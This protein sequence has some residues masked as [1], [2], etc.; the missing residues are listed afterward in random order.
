M[1]C[2]Q[3]GAPL[4][5]EA[6][7]CPNCGAKVPSA[8]SA[9][10]T[11]P[12]SEEPA[13]AKTATEEQGNRAESAGETL[14]T[15]A[16]TEPKSIKKRNLDDRFMDAINSKLTGKQSETIRISLEDM[17]DLI[18]EHFISEASTPEEYKK[19]IKT[20]G[21]SHLGGTAS[22]TTKDGHYEMRVNIAMQLGSTASL[23]HAKDSNWVKIFDYETGKNYHYGSL[24]W[25]KF[26]KAVKDAVEEAQKTN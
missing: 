10:E 19:I 15:V 21:G 12:V 17:I 11:V 13:S 1:F 23:L 26:K 20:A 25:G 22:L 4:D 8:V 2:D 16:G 18:K 14:E 7:F 24:T 6:K 3:C 9:A 5:E